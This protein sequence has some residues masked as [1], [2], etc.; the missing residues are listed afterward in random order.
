MTSKTSRPPD[1]AVAY[2]WLEGSVPPPYHYEYTIRVE[3]AGDCQIVFYPD[4]PAHDPPRWVE[5]FPVSDAMMD[6][7]HALI[8]RHGLLHK[9][10]P[11]S[12]NE[13]VG[14]SQE[15]LEIVADGE[16]VRLPSRASTDEDVKAVYAFIR[17][18]VPKATWTD[19]MSR[20][21]QF[22]RDYEERDG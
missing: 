13:A 10:W 16:A 14:G 3:P 22:E 7:L 11:V 17:G 12:Q 6:E 4:Y 5:A 8:V 15:W 21:E 2:A 9:Q 20:R 1:F 19:L 18:L